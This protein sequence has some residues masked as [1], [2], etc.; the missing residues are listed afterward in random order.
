MDDDALDNEI[1]APDDQ[2]ELTNEI[3]L[4]E[5][6]DELEPLSIDNP[7]PV[8]TA[9]RRHGKGGAMM[10]AGMFG[11][12]Q[13]LTGRQKPDNVQIQEAPTDPIDVDKDGI[14]V[15]IDA[16]VSVQAPALERRPPVG[17]NKKPRRR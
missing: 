17:L 3:E 13:A 11:L 14:N 16:D 10:A 8:E 12:D 6:G 9:R 15:V 1:D 4:P 2:T 7:N 5:E